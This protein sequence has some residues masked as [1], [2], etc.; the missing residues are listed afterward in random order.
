MAILTDSEPD[1]SGDGL[2]HV[3]GRRSGGSRAR[4]QLHQCRRNVAVPLGWS[5][6]SGRGRH[7]FDCLPAGDDDDGPCSRAARAQHHRPR[8]HRLSHRPWRG[9]HGAIPSRVPPSEARARRINEALRLTNETLH[10]EIVERQRA[11]DETSALLDVARDISGSLDWEEILERCQERIASLLPCDRIATFYFDRDRRAFRV[12]AHRGIPDELRAQAEAVEFRSG[13]PIVE[14]LASGKTVV[15]NDARN[16]S[17]LDPKLLTQFGIQTLVGVPLLVRGRV[18]GVMTAARIATADPFT[19]TQVRWLQ[20]VCQHLAVARETVELYRAQREETRAAEGLAKLAGDMI[21]SLSTPVILDR[22]CWHTTKL[23]D[24]DCSHTF[25]L[26]RER[27]VYVA[28]SG[29][30]DNT[31]ESEYLRVIEVPPS[32]IEPTLARLQHD[33]V[34]VVAG[35]PLNA[36]GDGGSGDLCIALRRGEEIVGI[37]TAGYRRRRRHFSRWQLR[38]PAASARLRR[39]RSRTV[40]CS[41]SSNAPTA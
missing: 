22:L 25:L 15:I 2:P 14:Q 26:L 28:V 31:D 20:G 21:S 1:H 11:N 38:P 12:V 5:R 8:L 30:G 10:E 29:Y 16:Q 23:L 24:C 40:G 13:E 33:G 41:N 35:T 3:G 37:Q 32:I 19:A 36:P 34:T 9:I 27:N 4:N 7:Q 39:C 17:S 6:S 18:L